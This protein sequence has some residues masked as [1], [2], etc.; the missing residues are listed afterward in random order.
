VYMR[1][2]TFETYRADWTLCLYS[3]MG[4]EPGQYCPV[5]KRN[6]ETP[7]D[8]SVQSRIIFLLPIILVDV[9]SAFFAP[10]DRFDSFLSSR[11]VS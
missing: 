8:P 11:Y 5:Y 9:G 6:K 2:P 10:R 1:K 7:E 4:E 3:K